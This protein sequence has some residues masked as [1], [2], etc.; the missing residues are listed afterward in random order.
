ML[1]TLMTNK[2]VSILVL[3]KLVWRRRFSM[4]CRLAHVYE[5]YFSRKINNVSSAFMATRDR[6]CHR[7]RQHP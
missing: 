4:L 7:R 6:R 1:L 3:I 2:A 5:Y